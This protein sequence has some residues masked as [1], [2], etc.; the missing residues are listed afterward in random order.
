MASAAVLGVHLNTP[1]LARRYEETKLSRASTH[2]MSMIH[3]THGGRQ[4]YTPDMS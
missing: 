2:N 3:Q 1:A 4:I